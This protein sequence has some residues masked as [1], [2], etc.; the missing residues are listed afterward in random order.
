MTGK[1][2]KN[3][4]LA[5]NAGPRGIK[6]IGPVLSMFKDRYVEN[7][8]Q[9]DLTPEYVDQIIEMSLFEEEPGKEGELAQIEDPAKR[10]E[11]QKQLQRPLRR[12]AVEGGKM[13]PDQLIKPL[14]MALHA[15][16]LEFAFPYLHFHRWCW[17]L[18]RAV[19]ESTDGLL[20]QLYTPD[21]LE[22]ENQLPWV[23]GWIFIS[24]SGLNG[25]VSD[26]RLL[27]KAAEALNRMLEQGT[28]SFLIDQVLGDA[29]G[30]PV[31]FEDE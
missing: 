13:T 18:L 7:T 4:P 16:T 9:V 31:A 23:V 12:K 19:K 21:Y 2:R 29:L 8:G 6:D 15:E 30:I 5:S 20:R 27:Q 25:G 24:A 3:T 11:K 17:K 28:G 22:R 10:Q 26:R 14:V 1:S